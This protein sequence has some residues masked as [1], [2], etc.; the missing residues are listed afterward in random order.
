MFATVPVRLLADL[1]LV[2]HFAYALFVG[3]GLL[4]ILVGWLAGWRWI[5]NGWFRGLHLL[6]VVVVVLQAWA[7]QV[8]PLT[9]LEQTLRREAGQATYPGS[10][11]AHWVQQ[12]LFVAA[13]PWVFIL[14]YTA[15]GAIV[16]ASL[17]WA[18]P[19]WPWRRTSGGERR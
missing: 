4:L 3:G 15:G 17:W 11:I 2:V 14:A 8:C 12:L 9:S 6:A 10:F 5:G 18:P 1:V 7:G 19:R 13:P 16:V